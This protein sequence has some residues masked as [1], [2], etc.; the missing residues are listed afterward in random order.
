M[1]PLTVLPWHAAYM[2]RTTATPP[3]TRTDS[4]LPNR[5]GSR[6]PE[7]LLDYTTTAPILGC[8]PRMVRKLVE[9]RELASVKVGR[10]VRIEPDA[11][12]LY[13]ESHRR[14]AVS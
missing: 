2:K 9:N 6:H 13:I 3:D 7:K 5:E 4:P 1:L 11:I 10:L 14:K 12:A 8:S